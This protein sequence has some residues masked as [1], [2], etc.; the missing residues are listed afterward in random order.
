MWI[1]PLAEI[2]TSTEEFAPVLPA[3][4][5]LEQNYPNPFNPVT[6]ISYTLPRTALV[7]LLVYNA[8]GQRVASLVATKQE[9]GS[10]VVHG[11][12]LQC[13]VVSISTSC[14]PAIVS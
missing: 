8:L 14:R 7:N 2:V 12:H 4:I 10:H 6:K 9:A 5:F 13:P 1:R 11:M 3:E